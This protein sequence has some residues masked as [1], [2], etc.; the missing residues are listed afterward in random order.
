MQDDRRIT[1]DEFKG[2][3]NRPDLNEMKESLSYFR[4]LVDLIKEDNAIRAGITK[5]KYDALVAE[6]FTPQQAL[7]LCKEKGV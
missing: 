4:K 5:A 7:E 6:G 3:S 1:M 2:V